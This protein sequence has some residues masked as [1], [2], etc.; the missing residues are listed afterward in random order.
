MDREQRPGPIQPEPLEVPM[1]SILETLQSQ[2]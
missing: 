1:K 2:L